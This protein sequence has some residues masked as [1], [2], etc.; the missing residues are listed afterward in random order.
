MILWWSKEGKSLCLRQGR[1]LSGVGWTTT[2]H[3]FPRNSREASHSENSVITEGVE[4]RPQ[5]DGV[6]VPSISKLSTV[7]WQIWALE[8]WDSP[9]TAVWGSSS[10]VVGKT[11]VTERKSFPELIKSFASSRHQSLSAAIR[12]RNGNSSLSLI[13]ASKPGIMQAHVNRV[14]LWRKFNCQLLNVRRKKGEFSINSDSSPINVG[15]RESRVLNGSAQSCSRCWRCFFSLGRVSRLISPVWMEA[16]SRRTEF[17]TERPIVPIHQ[18]SGP[19]CVW[20]SFVGRINSNAITERALAA[21][22][23]ATGKATVLMDRTRLIVAG[24]T[25]VASEL[26][27]ADA[28]NRTTLKIFFVP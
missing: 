12:R 18:T 28:I 21:L 15:R 16:W 24:R 7:F 22:D 4:M 5:M 19:S 23:F 6:C 1:R 11:S 26:R 27:E 17:A 3:G 10:M 20:Q 25:G 8:T 13:K 9:I 14:A 2:N